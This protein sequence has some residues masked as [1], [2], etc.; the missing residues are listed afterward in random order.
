MKLVGV[1]G[2]NIDIG[3]IHAQLVGN[4]LGKAGEMALPLRTHASHRCHLAAG[5]HL[6]ARAFIRPDAGTFHISDYA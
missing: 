2:D 4:N 1:T 6:H 5:L 3:D